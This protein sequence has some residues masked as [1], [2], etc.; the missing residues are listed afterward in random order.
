MND[1]K[2][3]ALELHDFTQ[4]WDLDE[5]RKKL[6]FMVRNNMNALVFHEPGIEDKIVFPAKFLGAEEDVKGYYEVFLQ[7]DHNIYNHAL[8]EN[9]N[10]N[11]RAYMKH[12][13]REAAEAGVGVYF[14]NKELWFSD[15]ILKYKPDLI[16][17]GVICPSDPF[18]WEEFLPAKYKELF[19]A[20]PDLAGI[21]VSIG[22]GEARLAIS[23]TF[24]CGCD[25]CKK[26]D[27]A[28]W[29]KNMIMAMYGPFK[30]AG[31]TLVIRDFIYSKEEQE[32]FAQ[33]F[34]ELP[35][36]IVLS[37]KN[38]PHDF[39]PTFPNN[40]L[41]G[42][43]GNHPQWIEYDVNGQFFGW[44]AAPSTMIEDIKERMNYGAEHGVS[45]FIARSDW[46]G[47][48]DYT[49]FDNLNMLNLY[50][51]A[52]FGQN[53]DA[54]PADI[55]YKWLSEEKMLR[56]DIS[57][58]ELKACIQWME[59]IMSRTWPTISKT[60]FVNGA[61]FSNDSCVHVSFEQ[62][63]FI[64]ETH[65]SLKNW[66]PT[67]SDVLTMTEENIKQILAE[68]DEALR[69]VDELHSKVLEGNAGLNEAAY[70]KLVEHFDF[71][72]MYVRAFRL[73]CR[74]YCFTR[75]LKE[76]DRDSA[77]YVNSTPAKELLYQTIEE[78]EQFTNQLQKCS[79]M[80]KYPYDEMLDPE[81]FECFL[82][83]VREY[84]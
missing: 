36:D 71:M 82:K 42:G 11:R 76:N 8:R 18:W 19:I 21:V 58:Q 25:R 68:K 78:I 74:A 70:Q 72:R 81:R 29:Y 66:D 63:T 1:Y 27:P 26:L 60:V 49:C 4:I 47:V 31:K 5:I 15:F 44:G 9:L 12:L 62:P 16:K 64:G 2:I 48:Q 35:D 55:Y 30:E 28:E 23:N 69:M 3:R 59:E 10:L 50:G 14:E 79:F 34:N 84:C 52:A 51:I 13:I 40:P 37:L 83:G 22:T 17:D 80:R 57:P 54:K 38:T 65:H 32:R 41:T 75:Y 45:G 56:E 24:A 6:D 20:L 73:T 53:L 46:E 61:V 39:Y 33:A 67:K 7:I 43:V 77:L